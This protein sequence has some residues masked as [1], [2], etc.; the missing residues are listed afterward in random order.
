ML[1]NLIAD[2]GSTKTAWCLS[3]GNQIIK[4]FE[5]AGL[6]PFFQTE[7]EITSQLKEVLLPQIEGNSV[8]NKI[9]RAHV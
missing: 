9:G 8:E 4:S 7:D 2:S 3:Y 1:V 5:T 6:N